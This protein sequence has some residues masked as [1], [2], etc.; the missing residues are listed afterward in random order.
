MICRVLLPVVAGVL[1]VAE[2]GLCL[3]VRRCQMQTSKTNKLPGD[4]LVVLSKL[5][6]GFR[7]MVPLNP[8][9]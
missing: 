4:E 3:K 5:Y 8:E 2:F 9:E 6:V 1:A 7:D